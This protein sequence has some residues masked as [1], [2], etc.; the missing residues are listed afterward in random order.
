[1]TSIGGGG[2]GGGGA[3]GWAMIRT[4][5]AAVYGTAF[6]SAKDLDASFKRLEYINARDIAC[7][8]IISTCFRS[9]VRRGLILA[10]QGRAG[11]QGDEEP[12]I[13]ENEIKRGYYI[14]S[15]AHHR[16]EFWQSADTRTTR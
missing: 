13:A 11:A 1:M 16:R 7:W 6:F 15:P 5:I 2:E 14:V 12:W 8:V 3:T 9:A 10:S 4:S